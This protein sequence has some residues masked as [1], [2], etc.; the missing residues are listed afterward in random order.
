[1][2]VAAV[3][4]VAALALG[5]QASSLSGDLDE[6]RDALAG[7]RLVAT[8][9]ADDAARSVALRGADGK[10]VVGRSGDAALVVRGLPPAPSG[11]T[12]E[13]W[14]IEQ[15]LPRRAGLFDG[16]GAVALDRRVPDDAVV[17]VTLEDDGGA[18]APT[19]SP[20]FTASV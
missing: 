8:L 15:Q 19:G 5:L 17:A 20:L 9:L 14:V 1:V 4:A 7:Q 16:D 3:A 18:D 2:S 12:Y 10:V 11:K 13:I 6:T